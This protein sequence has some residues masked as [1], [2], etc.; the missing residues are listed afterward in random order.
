MSMLEKWAIY[1]LF[2][3]VTIFLLFKD[4][5][6]L[7]GNELQMV[8]FAVVFPFVLPFVELYKWIKKTFFTKTAAKK[9]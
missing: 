2:Q 1:S 4:N 8:T 3:A 9:K 5:K 7:Q 6:K